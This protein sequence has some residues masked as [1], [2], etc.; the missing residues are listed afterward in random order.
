ML[1]VF[2]LTH[3]HVKNKSVDHDIAQLHWALRKYKVTQ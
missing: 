1:H 2:E 3:S